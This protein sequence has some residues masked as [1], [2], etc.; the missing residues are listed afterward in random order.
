MANAPFQVREPPAGPKKTTKEST[1]QYASKK[2][3]KFSKNSVVF[4]RRKRI[5]SYTA[6]KLD[7]SDPN[8]HAKNTL[9]PN[10]W[11]VSEKNVFEHTPGHQNLRGQLKANGPCSGITLERKAL[12]V[13]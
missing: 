8:D 11:M 6:R 2:F 7:R 3:V 10:E 9:A 1:Y 13:T 12:R 4:L 5:A